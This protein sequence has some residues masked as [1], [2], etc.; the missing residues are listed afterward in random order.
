MRPRS[1]NWTARFLSVLGLAL[2]LRLLVLVAWV[3]HFGAA[4]LFKRGLEMSWLAESLLRGNGLSSPFGVPTGP[5]AFIAPAYPILIAGVFKLFGDASVSSAYVILGLQLFASLVTVSLLLYLGRRLFNERVAMV[6]GIFWAVSPP[7]L[8]LPTIF[9]ETS[10][11]IL[12]LMLLLAVALWVR[13][14]SNQLRWMLFG[15]CAGLTALVNPA[16]LLTLIALALVTAVFCWQQEALRSS[17]L[18]LGLLLF[19]LV[20]C[21]WPI[22]N[23]RVFHAFIPLRTTV[24]LELWMGNRA[25]ANGFLDESVFPAYNSSELALYRSEGELGYTN[26]KTALAR[27]YILAHPAT[28]LGLSLRRFARFWLGAG[29]QGGSRLFIAHAVLTT[30]FGLWGLGLLVK[31]RCWSTAMLLAAPLVCFPLPYY[32][33]HAEFRYRIVIDVVL[34]LLGAYAVDAATRPESSAV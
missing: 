21:A 7:L 9:W 23:A 28:F 4:Y 20:F 18:A 31:R 6:A 33:T 34:T 19:A 16:L 10:F 1:T 17:H 24:G 29:T 14:S 25:G 15:A 13:E 12:L 27:S 32:I 3:K 26:G 2:A 5:T 8:F 30:C 11:S 22:R